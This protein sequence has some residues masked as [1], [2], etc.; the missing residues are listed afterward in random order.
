MRHLRYENLSLEL[1][2]AAY[3][4]PVKDLEMTM[5]YKI[6]KQGWVEGIKHLPSPHFNHRPAN[7]SI[8]LLVIHNISLPP[9]Q[10]GSSD[11]EDFFLGKLDSKKHPYF[12][13]IKDLKVSAHFVIKRDGEIIQLVSVNDRAWHAGQSSFKGRENC[14]DYSVGIELEGSDTV[15]F[16]ER[17]YRS[18]SRLTKAITQYFP[19][20]TQDRI[21][22]HSSI[23]P[24]RKTDPGPHFDWNTFLEMLKH[25]N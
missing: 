18:L 14:N 24:G 25:A 6:D 8:D 23:A 5:P 13:T 11:I 1:P 2:A 12:E 16:T 19:A 15:D 3:H 21:T 22:G 10:F 7:T 9:D 4:N 17:Q 20:I